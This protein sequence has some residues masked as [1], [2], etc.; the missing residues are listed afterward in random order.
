MPALSASALRAQLNSGTA[1]P[2][3]LLL[4]RI[5][6]LLPIGDVGYRMN[7]FSVF[8][9][10]LGVWLAYRIMRRIG[11]GRP[12]AAGAAG[13]LAAAFASG[14]APPERPTGASERN[15]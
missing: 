10:A 3:Y 6:S 14:A 7:L 2:L 11:A 12:A 4:G 1:G 8:C 13:E 5:W 9:G 15:S